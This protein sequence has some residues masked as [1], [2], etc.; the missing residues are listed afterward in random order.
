MQIVCLGWGS[1]VWAPKELPLRGKW[2]EDGPFL[3]IEFARQSSG[4]RIT[5]VLMP[6]SFPLVRC[7]WKPMSVTNLRDARKALGIRECPTNEK[8]LTCVDYWPRGSKNKNVVKHVSRWA[9]G[10]NVDMVVW[11]N[12]PPRF[13]G[14]DNTIP[15]SQEVLG[16]LRSRQGEERERAEEYIRKAPPQIDTNYRRVIVEQLGWKSIDTA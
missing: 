8:P 5:L 4:G 14:R 12:L 1:L 3:P 13:N 16:Y 6:A 10:M 11:T 7:L 2:F 15:S 9:K